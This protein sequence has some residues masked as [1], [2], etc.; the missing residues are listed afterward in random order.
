MERFRNREEAGRR[1]AQRL[2]RFRGRDV[3][4]LGL[5]RGGVPVAAEVARALDAPLDVLVARKLGTPLNPELGM[6]AISEEGARYV[7]EGIREVVGASAAD[8]TAVIARER[9]E[10]DRRIV[11]YRGARPLPDVRDRTVILVDD[12]IATGGTVRAALRALRRLGAGEVVVAAPVAAAQ[13]TAILRQ[14][15]D[16]VVCVSEPSNLAAIGYWYD[17]FRQVEDEE[18]VEL[19]GG[20]GDQA[21]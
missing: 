7:D 10:L 13:T 1:L 12:G 15:A 11:H 17:D 3:V 2:G 20:A 14:E 8:V 5:P 4:V 16:E 21:A 18:V 9:A 6:G 19:L